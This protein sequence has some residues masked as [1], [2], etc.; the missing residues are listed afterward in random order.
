MKSSVTKAI[1]SRRRLVSRMRPPGRPGKKYPKRVDDRLHIVTGHSLNSAASQTDRRQRTLDD[2]QEKAHQGASS[3]L[4]GT[5][6]QLQSS[7]GSWRHS[8]WMDDRAPTRRHPHARRR[9]Q[10]PT[11]GCARRKLPGLGQSE[12]PTRGPETAAVHPDNGAPLRRR[13]SA[14]R[15]RPAPAPPPTDRTRIFAAWTR[16]S[17]R[18]DEGLRGGG[19]HSGVQPGQL[20]GC[21]GRAVGRDVQ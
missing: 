15:A 16:C 1:R 7:P 6:A 4:T 12:T 8:A 20:S 2:D 17:R 13:R 18:D 3:A 9:G 5:A 21:F 19:F 11:K 10:A 14:S